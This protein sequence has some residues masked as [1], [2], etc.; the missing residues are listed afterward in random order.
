[1]PITHQAHHIFHRVPQLDLALTIRIVRSGQDVSE[2]IVHDSKNIV[3][4][5]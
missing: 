2:V 5:Q 4:T 1:M 3:K